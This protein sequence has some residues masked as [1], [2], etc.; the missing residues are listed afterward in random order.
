MPTSLRRRLLDSRDEGFTLVELIV[1]MFVIAIVLLSILFVQANALTTNAQSNARQQA[2][3]YANEAME[4][5]RALPWNVLRRG[6]ANNFV[7]AAGGDPYVAGGVLSVD[8][9][10][11]PL[12]IAVAGG[13]D[14]SSPWPPL[15]DST[16]SHTQV[17]TDPAG[18]GTVFTVRSYVTEDQ[19]GQDEAMGLAVVVEYTNIDTGDTQ[20][21]AMFSTAYAPSGGCGDLNN[22]PFLASC[23]ALYYSQASTG[24]VVLAASVFDVS[25]TS[26]PEPLLPGSAFYELQVSTASAS[27]RTSSQQVSTVDAYTQF[28]GVTRDDA[29]SDTQPETNGWT[30]GYEAFTLRASDDTVTPG[31]PAV[32]P[33]DIVG[34][35]ADSTM[36]VTGT[37]GGMSI[38]ARS[39]D[40]RDSTLDASS[41][42]SCAT[43]IGASQVP[44]TQP[45]ASSAIAPASGMNG[46]MSLNL[47]GDTLRLGRV[48]H[49]SSSSRERAWGGRFIEGLMGNG[50]T[51]CQ[52]L[53]GSGCASAGAVRELGDVSV[54]AVVGGAWDDGKAP[55]G[56]VTVADY[57]EVV[58]AERGTSQ[59]A[60]APLLSRSAMVRY[61]TDSGYVTL[62]VAA[63][64]AAVATLGSV[65]WSH[66]LAKVTA[67]GTVDVGGSATVTEGADPACESEACSINARNGVITI[68]VNYLIEPS[69][70][71]DPFILSVTTTVNGASAAASYK[72][73]ENA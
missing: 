33:A 72:E 19:T 71:A 30:Q 24:S 29:D 55:T 8:G 48:T 23:Q 34:S 66:P 50:D 31:A 47:A 49:E 6:L 11:V 62:P 68:T 4:S 20:V 9:T 17:K 39:D 70:G 51:G 41:T 15:F 5:L 40:T 36:T 37:F 52:V 35:A 7:A 2:T 3:S 25:D 59:I 16:G 10:S 12:R 43:G 18:R 1:A 58:R 53:T 45:C 60:T 63:N 46:Y 28:G 42:T 61:W 65:T 54:G 21:T 57:E 73:P 67:T 13:Q 14:L 32:N 22:A 56:L 44:A 64:T 27:V 38:E 26:L 69:A